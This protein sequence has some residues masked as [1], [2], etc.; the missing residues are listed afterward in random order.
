MATYSTIKGFNVQVLSA[1][2]PAPGEGQVWYNTTTGTMKGYGLIGTGAWTAGGGLSGGYQ[3]G[4]GLGS[5]TAAIVA[6]GSPAG[7]AAETYNGTS[8]TSITAMTDPKIYPGNIG[9]ETTAMM[10]G[11]TNPPFTASTEVW[12]GAPASVKTVTVT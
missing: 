2:P 1:D 9:T 6:G 5:P 8:W 12:N 10:A 4:G 3:E 7:T 11:S